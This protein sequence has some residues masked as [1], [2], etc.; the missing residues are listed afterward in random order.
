MDRRPPERLAMEGADEIHAQL[1]DQA[2]SQGARRGDRALQEV[3]RSGAQG[4]KARR[5]LDR[6]GFLR[7]IR[8]PGR[9][10]R[11]ALTSFALMWS[12]LMELKL[13]PVIED[14][15]LV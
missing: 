13:V 1:C 9:R 14:A 5:A 11:R 4:R 7:R 15:Q 8:P 10:R 2:G 3:R 6:G 12:D